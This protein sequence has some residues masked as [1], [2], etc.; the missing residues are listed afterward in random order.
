MSH[1]AYVPDQ[2]YVDVDEFARHLLALLQANTVP[3]LGSVLLILKISAPRL[4]MTSLAI[5]RGDR[6]QTLV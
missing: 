1:E 5:A 2:V 3:P 6:E 4:A